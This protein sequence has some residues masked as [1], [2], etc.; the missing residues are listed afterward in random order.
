MNDK[1]WIRSSV[2]MILSSLIISSSATALTASAADA[3]A[4]TTD[5]TASES[6][7]VA[8]DSN[9]E[10]QS[11][12][13]YIES[14][15]VSPSLSSYLYANQALTFYVSVKNADVSYDSYTSSNIT[16]TKGGEQV[17]VLDYQYT[18]NGRKSWT[19]TE[20]GTYT[21]KVYIQD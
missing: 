5:N 7:V 14:F 20:T 3:A 12:D 4:A 1:K 10:P 8:D 21:A 16:I 6:D 9:E 19:P 15:S 18:D 2:A 13:I 17:A 11:S